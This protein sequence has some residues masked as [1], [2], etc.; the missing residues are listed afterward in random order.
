MT[1]RACVD[2]HTDLAA[3]EICNGFYSSSWVVYVVLALEDS[4]DRLYAAD[5]LGFIIELGAYLFS[6]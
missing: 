2:I 4:V 6:V 1:E 5:R 3:W